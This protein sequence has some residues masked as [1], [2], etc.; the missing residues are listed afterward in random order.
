MM[1]MGSAMPVLIQTPDGQYQPAF[2][3]APRGPPASFPAEG[4]GDPNQQS[5]VS[6]DRAC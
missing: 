2:Q 4:G 1:Q 6:L 3:V 5:Q